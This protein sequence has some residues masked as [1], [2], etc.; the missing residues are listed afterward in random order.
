MRFTVKPRS[1]DQLQA[2][3]VAN[4]LMDAARTMAEAKSPPRPLN[5][6]AVLDLGE[7]CY[8]HWRGRSYGVPPLPW[9]KGAELMDAYLELKGLGESITKENADAYYGALKRV[10][11]ILWKC[12]RPATRWRRLRKRL[13]L[14]GNPFMKASEGELGD[15]ALFYLGRRMSGQ[16][17]QAAGRRGPAPRMTPSPM[18]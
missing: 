9:K 3:A 7:L 17:I 1:W 18:T 16:R 15:L 10:A 5:V 13:R 14:L 6:G 4:G 8:F 11:R 2:D 12:T